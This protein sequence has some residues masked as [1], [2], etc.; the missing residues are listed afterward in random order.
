M[1]SSGASQ[2]GPAAFGGRGVK[3]L[4]LDR[5]PPGTIVAARR[6]TRISP[7][8]FE[9]PDYVPL[10]ERAY[11]QWDELASERPDA[12][13]PIACC[14]LVPADGLVLLVFSPVPQ[15]NLDVESL[16][17]VRSSSFPRF[18]VLTPWPRVRRA[19]VVSAS[20][21]VTLNSARPRPVGPNC[22]PTNRHRRSIDDAMSALNDRATTP[23]ALD[24]RRRTLGGQ[25][26]ADLGLSLE[27]DASRSIGICLIA[28]PIESE[29]VA[30]PS[31]RTPAGIFY[32]FRNSNLAKA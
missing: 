6:Q 11:L 30:R 14:K 1:S 27:V 3:A 12:L 26:L 22:T 16:T 13:A 15:H 24:H 31:C 25:L 32:G 17:A 21:C 5:F 2:L 9:H 10:V 20:N 18:R 19:L 8:H 28:K 7:R 4:R 29:R 23:R